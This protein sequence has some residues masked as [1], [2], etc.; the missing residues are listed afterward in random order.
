MK[1]I[2]AVL[3]FV[4]C[5]AILFYVSLP[6]FNF[7]APPPGAVQSKE[8]A[9]T[10][11]PLRRAYF[12]DQ[13]RAQVLEWYGSQFKHSTFHNIPLPTFLLNYPPEDA[14]TIIRDQ[15]RSTFLQEFV[16][17]FRETLFINGYEPAPTDNENRIVID[18]VH[19]RQ[20]IIVRY[21]PNS[22]LVRILISALTLAAI[23]VMY[24]AFLPEFSFLKSI[25][26]RKKKHFQDPV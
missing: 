1:K 8:P 14:Q 5:A 3:Y 15:T 4:F 13:T 25:F 21:I 9:D 19:Y 17:P 24:F 2:F 6:T 23:P 18:G 10:E 20:K 12:T 7:P 22:V 11:T 26:G 16:H